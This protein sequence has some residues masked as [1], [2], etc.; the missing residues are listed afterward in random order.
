MSF[1]E[2]QFVSLKE[3]VSLVEDGSV[4]AVTGAMSAPPMS[5]VRELIRQGKRNL[6]VVVSPIGGINVDMLIGA[7]C[8]A[9]AEFPQISLGEFGL[10]P[11]FR[12]AAEEGTIETLE[13]T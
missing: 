2:A 1:A 3:A 11:N 7:G 12:R 4:V 13:H 6:H 8:V 9:K 10:A 5:L